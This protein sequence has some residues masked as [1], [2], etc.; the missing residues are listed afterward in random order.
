MVRQNFVQQSLSNLYKHNKPKMRNTTL[1]TF[2]ALYLISVQTYAQNANIKKNQV[3]KLNYKWE[4]PFTAGM[5]VFNVYGFYLLGQKPNLS[6][7]EANALNQNDVW[8]FDRKVF[9]QSYPAPSG[10]YDFSDIVLWTSYVAPALLFFDKEIRD[11]WLDITILYFEIQSVNLNI[12]LW[13]GPIFTKRVRPLVYIEDESLDYKLGPETTDSFFSGHT[14]MVA[15]ASFFIAKVYT[16]YHPELGGKKWFI[17]GAATI[18]PVVVGYCRYR[19]FMH[20]PTDLI[21]GGLVGAAIGISVPHLHKITN[22]LNPDLSIV[23]FAGRYSGLACS[24][25]F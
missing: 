22:K 19:G 15:G 14:S 20:F 2:L 24:F 12:Y 25:K 16:D 5:F 4:A 7:N 11:S 6:I 21:L 13:C 23:P 18:P 17:Y 3:Y 1:L 9:S 10:I 8:S